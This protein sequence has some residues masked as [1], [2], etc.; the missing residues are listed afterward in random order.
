MFTIE[1]C[2]RVDPR[3]IALRA[4]LWPDLTIEQHQDDLAKLRAID[5]RP[6]VGFLAIE[7]AQTIG[8]A[9]AALRR[10]GVNG[11]DTLNVAFLEG[12]WVQ[13]AHRRR[14]V[15]RALIEAAE[16]WARSVG[17]KEFGSDALLENTMGQTMHHALGFE[18]T[19]R[20]VY[21]RKK[22]T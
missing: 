21:F 6:L 12:I 11:C 9:E 15:G 2:D 8:F 20:V 17:C 3:W 5:S 4:E 7:G 16:K 1:R 14:G 18:E 19:E 10:A 13:P 22:L